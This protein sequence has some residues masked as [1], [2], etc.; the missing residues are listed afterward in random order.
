MLCALA[1]CVYVAIVDTTHLIIDHDG[2]FHCQT[3]S[4]RDFPVRLDAGGDHDHVG[5]QG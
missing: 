2:P 5:L 3:S 1:D 4:S